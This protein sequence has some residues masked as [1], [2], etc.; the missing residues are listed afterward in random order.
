MG[1]EMCIRDRYRPRKSLL[2]NKR[3]AT[4][5]LFLEI[6]DYPG[7]WLL[8]LPLLEMTYKDWCLQFYHQ[9]NESNLESSQVLRQTLFELDP[10][11]PISNFELNAL[12]QQFLAHLHRCQKAGMTL[13]QPGRL[14]HSKPSSLESQVP[15]IPVI[16]AAKMSEE[17]LNQAPEDAIVKRCAEN[18]QHYLSL[19]LIHI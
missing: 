3:N 10:I 15:F 2:S 6:H 8:D 4:S 18:Y 16:K 17:Q 5:R 1:S 19:S 9:L 12:W 14:L 7:E 13:I 11:K